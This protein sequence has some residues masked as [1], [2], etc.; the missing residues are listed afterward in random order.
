[1]GH[2]S[3]PS[4][5]LQHERTDGGAAPSLSRGSLARQTPRRRRG[6][7]ATV[8]TQRLSELGVDP[9]LGEWFEAL[10]ASMTDRDPPVQRFDPDD[11]IMRAG[12]A[13]DRFYV[14]V[15]GTAEV[16]RSC[17]EEAR[18]ALEPGA[19]LGELGVLFG[20]RRRRTV[21]AT[22][23]VVA[24]TGTRSELERALSDERIGT[25][26][27]NVAAQRLAERVQPICATTSRGLQV[28]LH[29]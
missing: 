6:Y 12:E 28:L 25:H 16:V 9:A 24:I 27:A 3:S 8:A 11:A 22:S 23:P 2:G 29:P 7:P 26:V 19:L 4:L 15:S 1:M 21:V 14:I 17:D 20:G 5:G 10:R 18:L 13:A